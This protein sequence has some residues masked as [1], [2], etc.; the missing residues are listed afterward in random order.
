MNG[1]NV[2]IGKIN[3]ILDGYQLGKVELSSV[4]RTF[5]ALLSGK[6]DSHGVV[7]SA[8]PTG[9]LNVASARVQDIIHVTADE[10]DYA[11]QGPNKQTTEVFVF[12][13]PDNAGLI[14]ARTDVAAT[15]NNALPIEA[16]TGFVFPID[17][18]KQLRL[19][20][21]TDTEKAIILY[22]R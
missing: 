1:Q 6:S 4:L 18:L 21:K 20:I 16:K 15:V 11:Y 22:T 5:I 10:N 14:W 19:L 12:G 7:L 3:E 2:P 17:N 9:V 13:H 8:R